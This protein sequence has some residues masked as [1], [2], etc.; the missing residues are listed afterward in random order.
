VHI[1]GN[2]VRLVRH[3]VRHMMLLFTQ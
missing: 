3:R 1:A 2:R